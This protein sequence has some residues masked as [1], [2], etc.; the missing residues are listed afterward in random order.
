MAQD[1]HPDVVRVAL[2]NA[3]GFGFEAFANQLFSSLLG[4]G[5]IPL[6]GVKDGGAEGFCEEEIYE[7]EGRPDRFFQASI[8]RNYSYKIERTLN[9]LKE[10]GRSVHTLWYITNQLVKYVD[11]VEE[12]LSQKFNVN[13]KIRDRNYIV[14]HVNDSDGTKSAYHH[15]LASFAAHLLSV[16][17]A[18]LIKTSPHVS[19][20]APYVFLAHEVG[21]RS[22]N[23]GLIPSVCDSL[24]LW[25]LNDTDPDQGKFRS[26]EEIRVKITT[27]LPWARHYINQN[28]DNRLAE[29]AKQKHEL[30]SGRRIQYHKKHSGYC[31]PH[32][33]RRAIGQENANDELLKATVR[34]QFMQVCKEHGLADKLQATATEVSFRALE[35]FYENQGLLFVEFLDKKSNNNIQA[36]TVAAYISASLD[37]TD[38]TPAARKK[39]SEAA[40][41]VL[42]R[43]FYQ[44]TVEQREYLGRLARTY[45]LLFTMRGDPR[46]VEFFQGEV[47][48]YRLLVG[49]DV[50]LLALTERY[51]Q[52][53]DQRARTLLSMAKDFGCKLYLTEPILEELFTHIRATDYEFVNHF[54]E[55]EPYIS[56]E[57]ASHSDKILIRTYF[58]AKLEGKVKG[59][60]SFINAFADYDKIRTSTGREQL[61]SYL[62]NQFGLDYFD[63]EELRAHIKD[64]DVEQLSK[65]LL[66]GGVKDRED[67]ARNDAI[68]VHSVYGIRRFNH[69]MTRHGEFG[70]KTWWLTHEAKIQKVTAPIVTAN[71]GSRYIMRPAFLLNYFSLCPSA[72]EIQKSYRGIFPTLLGLQMGHRLDSNVYHQ[73]LTKV[74][75]WRNLEEGRR[76]AKIADL[77]DRLKTDHMRVHDFNFDEAFSS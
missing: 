29:L 75:E 2:D 34:E 46:I 73:T 58:Y 21:N 71:N 76:A 37:E 40:F 67:L 56:R 42:R 50:L 74:D 41:E 69:E 51:V 54:S 5:Y 59:W 45:V 61:K 36:S 13:I 11:R 44:S 23:K 12:E 52:S 62:L 18:P 14:N 10:F 27:E 72:G 66:K 1:I 43:C 24:I 4:A 20:P 63:N 77:S 33:T 49:T 9:R 65:E 35:R 57:L 53:E 39:L 60:R 68:M 16:G 3:T 28:I 48:G 55:R 47:R 8:E 64:A 30:G 25:A 26:R 32:E 6:G 38:A 15:A 31:L 7:V 19:D 22:G 70:Y 17:A